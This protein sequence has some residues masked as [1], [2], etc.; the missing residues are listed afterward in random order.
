MERHALSPSEASSSLSTAS[1]KSDSYH[2]GLLRPFRVLLDW[3]CDILEWARS[4]NKHTRRGSKSPARDTHIACLEECQGSHEDEF[5]YHSECVPDSWSASCIESEEW[6]EESEV[7]AALCT[8]PLS[9]LEMEM[10][11]GL[12]CF[13]ASESCEEYLHLR[14][15]VHQYEKLLEDH[16]DAPRYSHERREPRSNRFVFSSSPSIPH[17]NAIVGFPPEETF[18]LINASDDGR[19]VP[20]PPDVGHALDD[21]GNIKLTRKSVSNGA[22]L[23]N[24][25]YPRWKHYRFAAHSAAGGEIFYE[26]KVPVTYLDEG[27]SGMERLREMSGRLQVKW[28]AVDRN[29]LS[30]M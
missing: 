23:S 11:D 26:E 6:D 17:A 15:V 24:H 7:E 13:R 25:M 5:K 14:L 2:N 27:M 1:A 29:R 3:G 9:G 4:T 19:P 22:L 21:E 10:E 28:G 12:C 20:P 16:L 30:W 18:R 8:P